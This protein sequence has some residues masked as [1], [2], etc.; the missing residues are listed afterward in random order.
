VQ[1]LVV[2]FVPLIFDLIYLVPDCVCGLLQGE[3]SVVL[4]LPDRKARGFI[5]QIALPRCFS[6]CAHQI[7]SEMPVRV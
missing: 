4:K 3:T 5:V 6:E 2:F 7:F 1:L